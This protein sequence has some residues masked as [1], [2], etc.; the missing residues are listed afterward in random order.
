M[1]VPESLLVYMCV[2]LLPIL[3]ILSRWVAR[4]ITF[5]I[6]YIFSGE[7]HYDIGRQFMVFLVL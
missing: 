6:V 2:S 4:T 5:N 1:N 3:L 7:K